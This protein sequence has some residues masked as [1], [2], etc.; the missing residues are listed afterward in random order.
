VLESCPIFEA[1]SAALGVLNSGRD[2]GRLGLRSPMAFV[3]TDV[4]VA[5]GPIRIIGTG[6]FT[7]PPFL[8]AAKLHQAGHDVVMQS[9]SRSPAGPGGAIDT[10][11]RFRDNYGAGVSNFLYNVDAEDGRANWLCHETP[12]GSIDPA[13]VEALEAK[14]VRWA[15]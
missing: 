6:E 11:F 5:E 2:Y 9:T 8:L 14:L 4:P 12:E 3:P 7:Y 13:L 15:P 1:E 10:A